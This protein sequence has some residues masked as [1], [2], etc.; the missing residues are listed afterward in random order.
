MEDDTAAEVRKIR[1]VI[2]VAAFI[3]ALL[4]LAVVIDVAGTVNSR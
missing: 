3:A 4:L 1:K 2:Y